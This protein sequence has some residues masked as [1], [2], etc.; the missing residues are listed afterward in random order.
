MR[1]AAS[2]ISGLAEDDHSKRG[3]DDHGTHRPLR[4]IDG[5]TKALEERDAEARGSARISSLAGKSVDIDAA[6]VVHP[7]RYEMALEEEKQ[8]RDELQGSGIPEVLR[9]LYEEQVRI[10]NTSNGGVATNRQGLV[11]CLVTISSRRAMV[12]YPAT[13]LGPSYDYEARQWASFDT[14]AEES[15]I[16][17]LYHDYATNR[18]VVTLGASPAPASSLAVARVFVDLPVDNG[19][20]R[21][22][23]YT[24]NAAV[25]LVAGSLLLRFFSASRDR[26]E[27]YLGAALLIVAAKYAIRLADAYQGGRLGGPALDAALPFL[28]CSAFLIMAGRVMRRKRMHSAITE[29]AQ[30]WTL[31]IAAATLGL[32]LVLESINLNPDQPLVPSFF[33]VAAIFYLFLKHLGACLHWYKQ[34][35]TRY[36]QE[37]ATLSVMAAVGLAVWGLSQMW[38][39]VAKPDSPLPFAS[40]LRGLMASSFGSGSTDLWFSRIGAFVILLS[41]KALAGLFLVL[42]ASAREKVRLTMRQLHPPEALLGIADGRGYVFESSPDGGRWRSV[43]ADW[44]S[45]HIDVDELKF[46]QSRSGRVS[47]LLSPV[48]AAGS[49]R[50]VSITASPYDPIAGSQLVSLTPV[51]LN[52]V[53]YLGAEGARLHM[54]EH[55]SE[56]VVVLENYGNSVGEEGSTAEDGGADAVY[57]AVTTALKSTKGDA[58]YLRQLRG[59]QVAAKPRAHW[60]SLKNVLTRQCQLFPAHG[61][62]IEYLKHTDNGIVHDQMVV[63]MPSDAFEYVLVEMLTAMSLS[64]YDGE[65][66]GAMVTSSTAANHDPRTG[67][68]ELSIRI[69]ASKVA[70]G[71]ERM[72]EEAVQA[73]ATG[74]TPLQTHSDG[75]VRIANSLRLL[76]MFE[77]S[78]RVSVREA[79]AVTTLR[80]P[81][82]LHTAA[83][84]ELLSKK[85]ESRPS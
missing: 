59:G 80:I 79:L 18:G 83:H 67:N 36:N 56:L 12:I 2:L 40:E 78:L 72:Y 16:S 43:L 45:E 84:I 52:K 1:A 63:R 33:A 37:A 47:G 82:Y 9:G 62:D 48:E 77:A 24:L 11:Y 54:Q 49:T 71:Y 46:I 17:G 65:G 19:S 4:V 22:L 3:F 66:P 85:Q 5:A 38:M 60:G 30:W 76:E 69:K 13:S 70:P 81:Y 28:P 39:L 73:V 6:S 23:V 10:L 53:D 75:A 21:E 64:V 58:A 14:S 31:E 42:Y 27:L 74:G 7:I 57:E 32:P 34:V 44:L 41:A 35:P 26:H 55:L 25:A 51:D 29:F 68:P 61:A 50:L 8:I 20:S 15:Y